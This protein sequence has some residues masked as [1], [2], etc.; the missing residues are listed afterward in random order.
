MDYYARM[1]MILSLVE[2]N[3]KQNA[4]ATIEHFFDI[5]V[6]HCGAFK[7]LVL[8]INR[9]STEIILDY[10]DS[11]E[12]TNNP[13]DRKRKHKKNSLLPKQNDNAIS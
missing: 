1:L 8:N 5:G 13:N 11:L 4:I 2:L 10:T 3:F 7:Y 6:E 12:H 9:F